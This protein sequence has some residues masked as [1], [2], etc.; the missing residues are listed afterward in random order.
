MIDNYGGIINGVG[1]QGFNNWS[2]YTNYFGIDIWNN[3]AF[4]EWYIPVCS[5]SDKKTSYNY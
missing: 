5:T 1:Q 4:D 2:G 3:G